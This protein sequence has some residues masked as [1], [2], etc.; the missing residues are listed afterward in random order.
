M[1]AKVVSAIGLTMVMVVTACGEDKA[2]PEEVERYKAAWTENVVLA[3]EIYESE[4]RLARMC[5]ENLGFEDHPALY[6]AAETYWD[7]IGALGPRPDIETAKDI[8]YR[9]AM[10]GLFDTGSQEDLPQHAQRA[11]FVAFWGEEGAEAALSNVSS[12]VPRNSAGEALEWPGQE[13]H[14]L[15]NGEV[16]RWQAEGCEGAAVE[17]LHEGSPLEFKTQEAE[18]TSAPWE[19]FRNDEIVLNAEADWSLCLADTGYDGIG[20][21]SDMPVYVSEMQDSIYRDAMNVDGPG[22]SAEAVQQFESQ[23]K[24][25]AVA[26]ARCA[27]ETDLDAVRFDRFWELLSEQAKGYETSV[28]AYQGEVES[29]LVRAQELL[30]QGALEPVP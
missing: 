12:E 17:A 26:D 11:Y 6:E 25:L 24:D 2:A 22:I 10:P 21:V 28:F 30:E 1:R 29:L 19:M 3:S 18:A 20:S 9:E 7:V 13:I 14:E 4:Q 27:E 15:E 16:I 23:Q 8:G 5:M